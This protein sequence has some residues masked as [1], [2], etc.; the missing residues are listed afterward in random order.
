MQVC[1]VLQALLFG[2][3][4][5]V[6]FQRSGLG[7]VVGDEPGVGVVE[8]HAVLPLDI[9]ALGVHLIPGH[10]EAAGRCLT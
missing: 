5:P 2:L 1:R 8:G 6:G 9:A 4:D 3:L 10:A 7:L